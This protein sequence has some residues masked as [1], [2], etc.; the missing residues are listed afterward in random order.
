MIYVDRYCK[1]CRA[2]TGQMIDCD[3]HILDECS[4][5]CDIVENS[6]EYVSRCTYCHEYNEY[7]E[8]EIESHGRK[9]VSKSSAVI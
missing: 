7:N 9:D 6:A 1:E 5:D 4:N 8:K 2:I 3:E